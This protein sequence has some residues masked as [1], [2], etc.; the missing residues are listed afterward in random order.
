VQLWRHDGP[1]LDAGFSPDGSLVA[2]TGED[3][4][5]RVW[6][7]HTGRQVHSFK[8]AAAVRRI[9]F[10]PD[11]QVLAVGDAAGLVRLYDLGKGAP[12]AEARHAACVTALAFSPDGRRLLSAGQ[13][14]SAFVQ[15]GRSGLVQVRN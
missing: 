4:T 8:H 5:A 9:A 14:G 1:A 15:D 7:A 2:S 3:A 10:R 12:L 13:D 11:G 6:D